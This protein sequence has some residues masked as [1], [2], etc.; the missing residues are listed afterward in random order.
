MSDKIEIDLPPAMSQQKNLAPL[1]TYDLD[2]DNM[3]ADRGQFI[4]LAS[5][6]ELEETDVDQWIALLER[7]LSDFRHHRETS[8]IL[9]KNIRRQMEA[10]EAAGEN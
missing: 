8:P 9:K 4:F 5:L 10:A 3:N 7:I 2:L 6:R 1:T